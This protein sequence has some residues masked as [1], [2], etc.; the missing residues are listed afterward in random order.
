MKTA[1]H[2]PTQYET[3]VKKFLE[4]AKLFDKSSGGMQIKSVIFSLIQKIEDKENGKTIVIDLSSLDWTDPVKYLLIKEILD[5]LY[6]SAQDVYKKYGKSDFNTLV[7]L[8]EAH[9]IAPPDKYIED[10]RIY[11]QDVKKSVIRSYIETRKF[12]LGWIAISTRLSLLDTKIFEHARIKILG[13]GL[14]TGT[15]RDL[16]REQFGHEFVELYSKLPDPYDP[17]CKE[18]THV[19][20][21]C[22]PITLLSREK[23]ETFKVFSDVTTF[24][25]ENNIT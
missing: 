21:I 13:Y 19:F 16:L 4:I 17:F 25:S 6:Y 22:G 14:T 5:V 23:P 3:F 8:D 11:M 2:D 12:G 20:T 7:V 24:L 18:R 15:D 10:S 9:R 1:L